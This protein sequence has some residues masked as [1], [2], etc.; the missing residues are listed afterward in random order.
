[1]TVLDATIVNVAL[2]TLGREFGA[3]IAT[4]QWVTTAY[5]LDVAQLDWNANLKRYVFHAPTLRAEFFMSTETDRR[6]LVTF[7]NEEQALRVVISGSM[8]VYAGGHFTKAVLPRKASGSFQL[9]DILTP[10]AALG[11]TDEKGKTI[12]GD[13]CEASSVFG[14]LSALA[15][16]NPR[17]ATALPEFKAVLPTCDFVLCSDMGAEVADF[18]L[19]NGDERVVFVH[20][21][22]TAQKHKYSASQLHDVVMQ[23]AKNL[24]YLQPLGQEAPRYSRWNAP[25]NSAGLTIAQ[26]LREGDPA[27]LATGEKMSKNIRARIANPKTER[28]VWLVLGQM[29][30]RSALDTESTKKPPS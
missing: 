5:L 20:A 26:R 10:I 30:S 14:L 17:H 28:E 18:I 9:L 25:W 13:D 22:A 29:L 3:S 4:I 6:E 7:V 23:A 16:S 11:T 12:V 8:T 15:P 2:P 1:M 24:P 19:A 21:K 27:V